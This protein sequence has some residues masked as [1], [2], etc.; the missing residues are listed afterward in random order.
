[1]D[2]KDTA[3]I[4]IGLQND[5]FASDGVLNSNIEYPDVVLKHITALLDELI[6]TDTLIVT[7]PIIFSHKPGELDEPVGILKLIKDLEAFK[8]GTKGADTVPE[9]KAYG[10]RIQEIPGKVGLNAFKDTKLNDTLQQHNIKNVVFAGAVTSICIDS[11]GRS[12]FEKG[13]NV[14]QLSDCTSARTNVEQSFYCN[15]VFPIYAK[16]LTSK[17]LLA[18]MGV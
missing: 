3:L 17:E 4:L 2:T 16:V 7:T 9:I 6:K 15:I 10:N 12:A 13:Y 8:K 11:T 18:K 1:M 14:T 5:Y